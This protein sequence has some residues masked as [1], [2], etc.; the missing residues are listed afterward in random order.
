MLICSAV[1]ALSSIYPVLLECSEAVMVS[2]LQETGI[3]DHMTT[4][5]MLDDSS[6]LVIHQDTLGHAL[7]VPKGLY[8]GLVGML[9]VLT[10]SGPG[11]KMAR[12]AENIDREVDTAQSS[13]HLGTDLPPIVLCQHQ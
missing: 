10:R 11:M 8:Q 2:Q 7:K 1:D 12:V 3:E 9:C 5:V 4:A 6:F 13:R